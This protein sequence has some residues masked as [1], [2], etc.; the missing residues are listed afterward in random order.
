MLKHKQRLQ[1]GFTLI[2]L[3]V[4]IVIIGIIATI[5]MISINSTRIKARDAKRVADIKQMQ[6]A[7]ELYFADNLSYPTSWTVGQA[8]VSGGKTLMTAF[9]TNPRPRNDGDCNDTDYGYLGATSQYAIN[10]CLGGNAGNLDAGDHYLVQS[11]WG[12]GIKVAF[13]DAP[14]EGVDYTLSP[15]NESGQ[16]DKD[17]F[18]TCYRSN[19]AT[20]KLGNLVIGTKNCDTLMIDRNVFLPEIKSLARSS[21]ADSNVVALSRLLWSLDTNPNSNDGRI[22]IDATRKAQVSSAPDISTALTNISNLLYC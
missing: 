7:L 18:F 22:T 1:V 6:A 3:L 9:P 19:T 12:N 15:R 2:E 14:V 13:V 20:F 4:V 16:T 10:F 17:G 21:Y 5:V 11:G 8:L